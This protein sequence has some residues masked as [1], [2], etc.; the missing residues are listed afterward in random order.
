MRLGFEPRRVRE[1]TVLFAQLQPGGAL[2]DPCW[3]PVLQRWQPWGTRPA[4]P[5]H[6]QPPTLTWRRSRGPPAAPAAPA[7]CRLEARP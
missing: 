1:G 4:A 3:S 7:A 6:A 5:P 2:A